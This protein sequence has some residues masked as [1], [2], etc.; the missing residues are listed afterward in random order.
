MQGQGPASGNPVD[1]GVI[2]AAE[3]AVAMDISVCKMLGIEH[4]ILSFKNLFGYHL[5]EI[6]NL[7]KKRN[8]NGH[9]RIYK[10]TRTSCKLDNSK[11]S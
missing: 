3:N 8:K 9:F 5:D 10:H 4:I 1:L 6:V 11:E 2:L 7:L